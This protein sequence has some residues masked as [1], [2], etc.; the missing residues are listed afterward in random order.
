MAA[1]IES[2]A[3][4]EATC[5]HLPLVS[6]DEDEDDDNDDKEKKSEDDS[7]WDPP[8]LPTRTCKISD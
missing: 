4:C 7:Y 1:M 2:P 8:R 6:D 5:D 3:V